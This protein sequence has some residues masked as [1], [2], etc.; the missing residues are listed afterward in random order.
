MIFKQRLHFCYLINNDGAFR[1]V[2]PKQ[3]QKMVNNKTWFY[4]TKDVYN[5]YIRA[6]KG[7]VNPNSLIVSHPKQISYIT[8]N[9]YDVRLIVYP[10]KKRN[11]DKMIKDEQKDEKKQNQ[12]YIK[13][14][15]AYK[16]VFRHTVDEFNDLCLKHPKVKTDKFNLRITP[17]GAKYYEKTII[18]FN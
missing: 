7:V 8:G 12:T 18:H 13:L 2:T 10:P 14:K 6:G 11:W 17:N 1:K 9:E 5:R 15:T 3:A 4:T 16:Q